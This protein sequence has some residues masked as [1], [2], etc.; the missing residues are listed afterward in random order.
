MKIAIATT[1]RFHVLDLARELSA[2]GHDLAFYSIVPR[3]RAKRFGLA[4]RAHRGLLP[5][6][7]P[8]AAL[9]RFGGSRLRQWVNPRMLDL[10]DRLIARRLEP[11]DVFIGMSGLC[12]LSAL[13][14]RERFGAK[15]FIERGSR[16]IRSQQT[17]L[18]ALADAGVA[19]DRVPD[20]AVQRELQGYVIADR[21]VVPSRHAEQSFIEEGVPEWRLFRNPYGVELGMFPPL[22]AQ[23]GLTPTLLFVGAWTYQKGVD[24]LVAA[25][26][27]L[28]GVNLVHVGTVG[29]ARLPN[30]PGFEHHDSVPQWQL[31][32]YY[33]RAHVF[34]LASRQEG[35]ALVQAQALASGLP[36]VC[37]D[38]TGGEDLKPMLKDPTWVSVVP[39]DDAGALA[40]AIR[41]MLP[42]ATALRGPRD[43]LGSAREELSWAGYGLR[44]AHELA[45][46]LGEN[47]GHNN[48]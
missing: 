9:S 3:H 12:V 17:I 34:V 7:F 10:A 42:R 14:A 37:T 5:W 11:C 29:D 46:T 26:R 43:L 1:G 24:L 30:D 23:P 38:R 40:G 16:H 8:M 6:L 32:D 18:S 15:V 22:E 31:S 28:V 25:W 27:E 41:E 19:N 13:A 45:K 47:A 36:I 48:Q 33:R 39:H 4:A 44:Y 20:H 21:I 2:L 35:M